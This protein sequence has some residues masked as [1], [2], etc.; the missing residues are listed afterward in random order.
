MLPGVG[1][2]ALRHRVGLAQVRQGRV[3][4]EERVVVGGDTTRGSG[5]SVHRDMGSNFLHINRN[6]RSISLDLKTEGGAEA[7]R[8]LIGRTDVFVHNMRPEPLTRLGFDYPR[9][10]EL[11]P[12][13]V[14][15]NIWG[16]GRPAC[17]P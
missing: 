13:I 10:R 3:P 11:K 6:K 14:Y 15:C 5:P 16:F 4:T 7:M 12:D 8:R 9:V 17:A 2:G 1:H